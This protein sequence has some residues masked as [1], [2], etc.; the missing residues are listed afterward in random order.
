MVLVPEPARLNGEA[1]LKFSTPVWGAIALENVDVFTGSSLVVI[2]CPDRLIVPLVK[3]RRE[4]I[5]LVVP[6][7]IQ[8]AIVRLPL[9]VNDEIVEVR[10]D[11]LVVPAPG[12]PSDPIIIVAHVIDPAPAIDAAVLFPDALNR[13]ILV[14][15]V[16]VTP[17]FTVKVPVVEELLLKVTELTLVLTVT[18]ITSPGLINASSDSPGTTPPDQV[19]PE[20][21]LPLPLL[22]MFAL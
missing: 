14:V 22:V 16:R 2:S 6:V 1:A 18:V 17:T 20:F 13:E 15:T 4:L 8:L 3:L 7:P 12:F 21:Q 10:M 11:V 9:T 19:A 5:I